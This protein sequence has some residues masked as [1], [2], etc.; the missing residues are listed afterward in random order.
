MIRLHLRTPL[1]YTETPGLL[2]F[3][4]T[5]SGEDPAHFCAHFCGQKDGQEVLF[6]YELDEAQ[7]A[8]ID[9][10][11]HCFL[12]ELV[13]TGKGDGTQGNVQLPAG[14]YLFVQHRRI[15]DRDECVYLAIEQ[16]K[17]GLWE[18]NKP[19]NRLYIRFLF[20]DDSP[21]TQLFRPVEFSC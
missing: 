8:R 13:F 2:P 5:F 1:K 21:V 15:L 4:C 14:Q 17:D 7:A 20:E 12:G 3:G 11:A 9:P 6:C 19:G 10:E 18:R 16:Q